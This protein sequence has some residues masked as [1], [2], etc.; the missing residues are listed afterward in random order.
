MTTVNLPPDDD[1]GGDVQS[2]HATGEPVPITKS[3]AHVAHTVK[4]IVKAGGLHNASSLARHLGITREAL[5]KHALRP[6]FPSPILANG[7]DGE[8][9]VMKLWLLQPVLEWDDARKGIV[10]ED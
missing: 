7:R 8:D 10:R 4:C 5:R 3:Q 1:P 2:L 6:D 9:G